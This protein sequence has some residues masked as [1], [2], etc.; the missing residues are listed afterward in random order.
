MLLTNVVLVALSLSKGPMTPLSKD[1]LPYSI[2]P[3]IQTSS[4]ITAMM[5]TKE[6]GF[7]YDLVG[8]YPVPFDPLRLSDGASKKTVRYWR[9]AEIIH[10]RVGMLASA[11]FYVQENILPLYGGRVTG[12][13]IDQMWQMPIPLWIALGFGIA[14]A[15]AYRINIGWAN[16]RSRDGSLDPERMWTLRDDYEPGDLRWDPLGLKPTNQK[17]LE[18]RQVQEL[19]NGRLAMIAAAAFLAQE[20]VSHQPVF[21]SWNPLS[22]FFHS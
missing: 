8:A 11:G 7:A 2:K 17:A 13:A 21:K 3:T 15:E 22:C 18:I 16:P 10:S 9:E 4:A 5:K 12:P 6:P 14:L 20:A 1:G 19:T